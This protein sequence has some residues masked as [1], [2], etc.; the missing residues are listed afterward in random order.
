MGVYSRCSDNRRPTRAEMTA[1]NENYARE[2]HAAVLD[3]ARASSNPTARCSRRQRRSRSRPTT[4]PTSK[5]SRTCFTGWTYS[6]T[7]AASFTHAE[8]T[9]ANHDRADAGVRDQHD[10]GAKTLLRGPSCRPARRRSRTSP[11]ALDNMFLH[12][13]VGPFIAHAADP[14]WSTSNPTPAYVGRVAAVFDN[15]G[16]GVRGDLTA[17]VRAILL[18]PE[19]R[20][21]PATGAARQAQGAGAAAHAVLA[22]LRRQGGRTAATTEPRRRSARRRCTPSVFNFFSPSYAPPGEIRNRASSRP[23]SRSRPS[24]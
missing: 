3:R 14:R 16:A 1:P 24:T 13:N 19:A 9:D 6:P 23:S 7:G 20:T 22:R 17:V 12:P 11:H 18:D 4:R 2:L 15:N 8:R 21:A 5:A 10:H